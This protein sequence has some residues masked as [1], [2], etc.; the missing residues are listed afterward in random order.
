VVSK[1]DVF[2]PDCAAP[3]RERLRVRDIL[4]AKN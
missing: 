1:M 4:R 2:K 3:Q